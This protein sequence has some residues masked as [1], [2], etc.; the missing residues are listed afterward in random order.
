MVLLHFCVKWSKTFTE[1]QNNIKAGPFIGAYPNV[2]STLLMDEFQFSDIYKPETLPDPGQFHALDLLFCTIRCL[3]SKVTKSPFM[4]AAFKAI[5]RYSFQIYKSLYV[6]MED[7]DGGGD[8][9]WEDRVNRIS[10]IENLEKYGHLCIISL[11][12][13]YLITRSLQHSSEPDAAGGRYPFKR[14]G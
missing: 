3:V 2:L 5:L 6:W 12:A 11:S 9:K 4:S 7:V 13:H 10:A 1:R 14:G 8:I